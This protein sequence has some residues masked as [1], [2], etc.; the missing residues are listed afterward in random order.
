M[1]CIPS[2]HENVNL[3]YT[4]DQMAAVD[5]APE[6]QSYQEGLRDDGYLFGDE[7]WSPGVGDSGLF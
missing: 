7:L 2:S 4:K 5:L 6:T 1:C 3:E